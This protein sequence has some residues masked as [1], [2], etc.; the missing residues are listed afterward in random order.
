MHPSLG[1]MVNFY[2]T[3]ILMSWIG[4]SLPF[5]TQYGLAS[6]FGSYG[7]IWSNPSLLSIGTQL[8]GFTTLSFAVSAA[9]I[10][11]S[12]SLVFLGTKMVVRTA[13]AMFV[14]SLIGILVY[15][16]VA[17]AAG[18]DTFVANFN[19]LSGTTVDNI[20][21]A[22]QASAGYPERILFER[23]RPRYCLYF[24]WN[25]GLHGFRLFCRRNQGR[26]KIANYSDRGGYPRV[27]CG[28]FPILP[29]IVPSL[30]WQGS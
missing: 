16:G 25:I 12:M 23:Y 11:A 2:F 18:H 15:L 4:S 24:P 6:L 22:A 17:V 1:F 3:V 14:L 19:A 9:I 7:V 20:L 29:H 8:G 5:A 10:L 30:R 26:R 27:W 28:G 21:K 13:W